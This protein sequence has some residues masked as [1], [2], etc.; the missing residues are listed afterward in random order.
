MNSQR[1]LPT[2]KA[3]KLIDSKLSS[4]RHEQDSTAAT[5]TRNLVFPITAEE[6]SKVLAP[7]L[8]EMEKREI[9]EFKT[10]YFFPV[11]ERKT[12]KNLGQHSQT[13][14]SQSDYGIF[15]EA[16]NHG[17]DNVDNEYIIRLNEHL[18]YR[19]EVVK[20]LGKGSF[21]VV[22]RCFDH[23]EKEFVAVKILKNKKRL[24]K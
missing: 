7:Y 9:F 12:Q 19:Y 24:Y 17:Y 16:T 22:M 1:I 18:G 4:L 15:N 6:A 3:S 13:P 5:N 14:G 11:N 21:G 10:I 8:W 20:K 23:K 2:N